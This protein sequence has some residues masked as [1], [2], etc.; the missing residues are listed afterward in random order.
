LL[1]FLAG[2]ALFT[3]AY[4]AYSGILGRLDGLPPLP[5]AFLIRR[6]ADEVDVPLPARDVA[7][8]TKL[9]RA[10]GP[11]CIETSFNHKIELQKN[12]VIL[13]TNDV[14]IEPDGRCRLKP[15]SIA[16]V[17][18]R[19]PTQD[20]EIYTIHS[21]E[22]FLIFD[23]PAKNLT[24]I[25]KRRIVGCD[26]VSDPSLLSPDPRCHR[27]IC[28]H[29]RGT[30]D[31]DDDLIMETTGPVNYRELPDK[32]P[33]S[34]TGPP[35]IQTTS[36]VR[37]TDKRGSPR[38]TTITAQ[39]MRIYLTA[40]APAATAPPPAKGQPKTSAIS[41]VHKVV[42]PETV[43]M[44]VWIDPQGGFLSSGQPGQPAP[45]GERSNV[46]IT[47]PGP[48]VYEIGKDADT[49]RFEMRPAGA[50][51]DRPGFVQVVRPIVK[52]DVTLYDRL[53]CET[54]ELQFSHKPTTPAANAGPNA[55]EPGSNLQWVH[56]W[57]QY[58]VLTSQ[59]ENTQAN[60]KDL[61]HDSVAKSTTLKGAP[62]VVALKDGHEIHAPELV[63]MN[64][65]A[66]GAQDAFANGTGYFKGHVTGDQAGKEGPRTFTAVWRD[67]MH[68]HK[69]DGEETITLIGS[70][71]FE[72]PDRKQSLAGE[73][74]KLT[75]APDP[76]AK[77][78]PGDPKLKPRRLEVT[79][80][81][82]ADTQELKI[83]DTEQLVLL[84]KDAPPQ[85]KPVPTATSPPA[86]VPG[87]QPLP[88]DGQP[89]V[90]QAVEPDK[91][92]TM[93]VSARSVQAFLLAYQSGPT[94]LETVHCEGRVR[95]HQDPTPPQVKPVDM[96]GDSLDVTRFPE[97]HKLVITGDADRP[98][99]VHLP[100]LSLA[101]PTVILHQVENVAE[102]QGPGAMNILSTTDFQGNKLE[103]PT[104]LLITWRQEMHF[105]GTLAQFQGA[106]QA[107]QD[108]T[109][110]TCHVMQVTLDKPVRL[111]QQQPAAGPGAARAANV[112]KVLCETTGR[113]GASPVTVVDSL[114]ENGAITR[115]QRIE[116]QELAVFKSEG[117][118]EAP[119]PGEV[120]IIQKGPK[121]VQAAPRPLAQ[122]VSKAKA[123]QPAAP[124]EEEQKLTLVRYG[125]KLTV[126]NDKHLAIFRKNVEVLHTA[127]D[128][129]ILHQKFDEIVAKL[130]PRA[131]YLKC[132]EMEIYSQE[133]GPQKYHVL[134]A[135]TRAE[136]EVDNYYGQADIITYDESKQQITFEGTPG[137]PAKISEVVHGGPPKGMVGQKFTYNR[138]T[139]QF[140]GANVNSITTK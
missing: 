117:R 96:R 118:L 77:S 53:D 86:P 122:P 38:S 32:A 50:G 103:K 54:L 40:G 2:V 52:N 81:V 92:P 123:P 65:D 45:A 58:V 19:G 107:D 99:E 49:A 79:G 84:F 63:L 105:N 20:P 46:Q 21:D 137:R 93:S 33:P 13:A 101:G 3:A 11:N 12:G 27:I 128:N 75:L 124:Q 136:I 66:K 78:A 91:K 73:Q 126:L 9:Q 64:S 41:G 5:A 51:A 98:A 104:E 26:L 71:A 76:T 69:A 25:G 139:G 82:A 72:D 47:T 4:A 42:L 59:A 134:I 22:A 89:P 138:I 94:E 109:R 23:E 120:R 127:Y 140:N 130:P 61:F 43:A 35:Q 112:E 115:Y 87:V 80:R 135:K 10:F 131:L 39:G 133:K 37:L 34:D 60:C 1:L 28:V 132:D 62:E 24:E 18:E 15:F 111:N 102:V 16:V 74:I 7:I 68:Y 56:A 67:K 108:N 125:Q 129:P 44:D 31:P 36:A 83:T 121:D 95:V 110:L 29:N 8:D 119:G 48:F 6:A 113:D 57:G 17:K 97:G 100:D 116:S 55:N 30:V 14:K 106:V 70:A 88:A 85:A 90:A 114:R